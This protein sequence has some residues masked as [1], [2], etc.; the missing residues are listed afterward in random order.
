MNMAERIFKIDPYSFRDNS[1]SGT[2]DGAI[3]KI[4]ENLKTVD[5]C[6]ETI[7]YLLDILEDQA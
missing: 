7:N 1:E 2:T 5:G 3:L 6:L 4:A